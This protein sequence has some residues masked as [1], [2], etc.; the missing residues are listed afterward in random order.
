MVAAL[1]LSRRSVGGWIAPPARTS[2][3]LRQ[4]DE[5]VKVAVPF[6]QAITPPQYGIHH[7]DTMPSYGRVADARTFRKIARPA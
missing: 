7:S 6:F 4:A 2:R 5:H 3:V 1:R